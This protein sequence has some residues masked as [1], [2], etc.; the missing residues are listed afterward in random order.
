MPHSRGQR[1]RAYFSY[2]HRLP[3]DE[4]RVETILIY[5]IRRNGRVEVVED[6]HANG[7]FSTAH[8]I[9]V[10]ESGV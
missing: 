5:L 4:T 3:G 8:W 1:I 7:L 6:R 10:L 9:E 2:V